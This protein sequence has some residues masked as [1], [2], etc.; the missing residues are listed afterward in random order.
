M[1]LSAGSI[2]STLIQE[3]QTHLTLLD[4]TQSP[5]CTLGIRLLDKDGA[6]PGGGRKFKVGNGR[7]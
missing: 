6:A 4:A 3:S 2:P 1:P 5:E 7:D